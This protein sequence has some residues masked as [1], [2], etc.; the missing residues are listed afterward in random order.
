MYI[1]IG[2]KSKF[3]SEIEPTL[4][5]KRLIQQQLT[6]AMIFIGSTRMDS[7]GAGFQSRPFVDS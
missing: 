7:S 2:M 3:E 5:F 4:A 1:I 6:V